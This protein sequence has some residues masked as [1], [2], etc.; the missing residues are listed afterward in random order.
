M[1]SVTRLG[2]LG[3]IHDACSAVPLVTASEDCFVNGLG[4]G[5]VSD[6]YA[7]HSCI[8]HPPHV[9]VIA[10]GSSSVFVNGLPIARI[11]DS[12]D[13]SGVVIEGSPNVFAGG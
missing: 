12:T 10:S 3:A 11:G 1:A 8:I 9:P 5:R 4:C 7:A 13:C 2:D 6:S